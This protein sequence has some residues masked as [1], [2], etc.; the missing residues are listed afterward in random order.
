MIFDKFLIATMVGSFTTM[1]AA[2]LFGA[3]ADVADVLGISGLYL[4]IVAAVFACIDILPPI[5]CIDPF[6]IPIEACILLV[7]TAY[8]MVNSWFWPLAG[9]P[10]FIIFGA[11][12]GAFGGFLASILTFVLP[13]RTVCTAWLPVVLASLGTGIAGSAIGALIGVSTGMLN[14]IWAFPI[15]WIPLSFIVDFPMG[16]FF[17]FPTGAVCGFFSS[18]AFLM[19]G[20]WLV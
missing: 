9:T 15:G 10:F 18:I 17:G 1:I 3:I 5:W 2:T 11:A 4:L 19:S 14:F 7:L 13:H 12:S 20:C 6:L 8:F 16:I